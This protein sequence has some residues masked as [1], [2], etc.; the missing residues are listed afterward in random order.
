MLCEE[1]EDMQKRVSDEEKVENS[2]HSTDVIQ[3]N[4]QQ[5]TSQNKRGRPAL[6]RKG[7][8]NIYKN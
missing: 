7:E 4:P 8:Q 2:Q 6:K 1:E 5:Q 3:P